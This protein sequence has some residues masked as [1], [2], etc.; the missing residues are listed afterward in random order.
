MRGDG[1]GVLRFKFKQFVNLIEEG[2][3]I[4]LSDKLTKAFGRVLK[5]YPMN[6]PPKDLQI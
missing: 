6:E 4:I 5:V 1:R 2:E 3:K